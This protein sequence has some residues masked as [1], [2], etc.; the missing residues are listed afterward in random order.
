MDVLRIDPSE[1]GADV[2]MMKTP[3]L[4][5]LGPVLP[6]KGADGALG[7][8]VAKP[9]FPRWRVYLVN[10]LEDRLR[11]L[12]IDQDDTGIEY[13]DYDDAEGG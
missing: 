8:I 11:R 3:D 12:V 9:G 2:R 1:P 13:R 7:V 6:L 5:P 4:W 10:L